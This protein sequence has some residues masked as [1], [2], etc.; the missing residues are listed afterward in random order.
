M[1]AKCKWE[2]GHK[3]CRV[4]IHG[5]ECMLLA[6]E[7]PCQFQE[8]PAPAPTCPKCGLE[9]LH[10]TATWW[11]SEKSCNWSQPDAD[12][13]SKMPEARDGYHYEWRLCGKG[14][15][16]SEW[17]WFAVKDAPVP[18]VMYWRHNGGGYQWTCITTDD[19]MTE[20]KMAPHWVGTRISY[21][22]SWIEITLAEY[23]AAK[24]PTETQGKRLPIADLDPMAG[25]LERTEKIRE[26]IKRVNELGRDGGEAG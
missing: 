22:W 9:L 17:G 18:V 2:H 8:Q 10:N 20:C 12:Q 1:T 23:E 19:V 14:S 16:P 3:L 15:T 26:L 25:T 11:C 21:E 4:S 6:G 24:K 13:R 7:K 5:N